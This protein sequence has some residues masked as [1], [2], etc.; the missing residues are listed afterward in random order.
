MASSPGWN[1]N[2]ADADPHAGVRVS[3]RAGDERQQQQQDA[4]EAEDV[5]VPEQHAV[6]AQQEDDLMAPAS[7]IAVHASCC[8]EYAS[9]PVD[10]RRCRCGRSSRCRGRSSSVAIGNDERVGVGGDEAQH[11]VQG[12]HE[13]GQTAAE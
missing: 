4:D 3:C 11:D 8:V 13:H 2:A 9:Q 1:A 7:A 5:G 10:A 6:V 12:E